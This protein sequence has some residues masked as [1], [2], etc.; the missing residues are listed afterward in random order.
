MPLPGE[1]PGAPLHVREVLDGKQSLIE[2]IE[3]MIKVLSMAYMLYSMW[4][5]AKLMRPEL[6]IQ[7]KLV[8]ARLQQ[9]FSKPKPI[10]PL[11]PREWI[12]A[13]Y[14]DTRDGAT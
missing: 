13:I 10:E 14:D 3:L 11:V 6:A 5:L 4:Q 8:I 9:R 12:R 2:T 7:E 1:T